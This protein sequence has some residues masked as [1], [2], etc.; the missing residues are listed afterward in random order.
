MTDTSIVNKTQPAVAA[1]PKP[2][3]SIDGLGR[4]TGWVL[5]ALALAAPFLVYPTFLMKGLCLAMFAMAFNLLVGYVGLLSFGHAAFFGAAGYVAGHA[6]KVWGWPVEAGLILA[7]A[8]SAVLGAAFGWLAIRRQGIYFAMITLALS[9]IIYFLALQMPQTGGEDGLQAIPRGHLLGVIDLSNSLTLYYVILALF[10]VSFFFV[11]RTINSP[12][13]EILRAIRD[14][15]DRAISLGY[16]A[17]QYKLLAFTLSAGLSGLAGALKA[18]VFQIAS[19]SDVHWHASGEV[20]LMTLLGGIGT[21]FG[22]IVGAMSYA[23]LQNY[24][25]AFGSWV[26][27]IQGVVFVLCVLLFRDGLV[28]L[29]QRFVKWRAAKTNERGDA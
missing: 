23:A 20:V 24:L 22:P 11:R 8:V 7:V 21:S 6:L 4:W 5:L 18:L 17:D 1:A 26:L 16:R 2:A 12:F 19:L 13:G 28:G 15:E 14:N 3:A 27:I 10:V 9:Q 25:A 29:A